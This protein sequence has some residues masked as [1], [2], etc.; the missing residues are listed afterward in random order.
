MPPTVTSTAAA[1]GA[2]GTRTGPDAPRDR[3]RAEDR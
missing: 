2:T 1:P 3:A